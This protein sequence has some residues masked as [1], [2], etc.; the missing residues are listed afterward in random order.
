MCPPVLPLLGWEAGTVWHSNPSHSQP[1]SPYKHLVSGTPASLLS[2]AV[3][4]RLWKSSTETP[5]PF[6]G[7]RKPLLG[8]QSPIWPPETTFPTQ[9]MVVPTSQRLGGTRTLFCLELPGQWPGCGERSR[10]PRCHQRRPCLGQASSF[11][12]LPPTLFAALGT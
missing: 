7:V 5:N 4:R 3:P 10:A 1:I 12:S 6:Q 11:A 2:P 8:T 9:L